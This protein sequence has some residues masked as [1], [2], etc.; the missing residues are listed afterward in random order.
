VA[1]L[2]TGMASHPFWRTF[3]EA[4]EYVTLEEDEE[5]L[6]FYKRYLEPNLLEKRSLRG[7]PQGSSSK[8]ARASR[9]AAPSEDPKEPLE[10]STESL[11]EVGTSLI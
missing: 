5:D 4:E 8:P 7:G 9:D 1:S 6:C 10:R 2:A 3:Q 11:M